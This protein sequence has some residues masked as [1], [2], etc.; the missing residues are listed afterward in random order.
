MRKKLNGKL[1]CK[2]HFLH[3]TSNLFLLGFFSGQ[4]RLDGA[5]CH[6]T[7]DDKLE[8]LK[9]LNDNG[10]SNIEME[11]TCFAALTKLAGIKSAV[12]CVTLVNRLNED[13]L[14]PSKETMLAWQNRP[15]KLVAE[16]I[17]KCLAQPNG[18]IERDRK[19]TYK[20]NPNQV[21]LDD[22]VPSSPKNESRPETPES[23]RYRSDSFN[24]A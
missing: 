19:D 11:S 4:A 17:K 12:V 8:Y 22:Y 16:Y 9:W 14:K 18:I 6:Y 3:C 13:Q 7:K 21:D 2:I 24:D 23:S 15:Q 5:F 10:V 1:K 20:P